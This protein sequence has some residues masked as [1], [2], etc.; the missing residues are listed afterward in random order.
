MLFQIFYVICSFAINI[1]WKWIRFMMTVIFKK[2]SWVYVS[3]FP[4][5][6]W[7]PGGSCPDCTY[8]NP[9]T[10]TQEYFLSITVIINLIH[11]QTMLYPN[12]KCNGPDV[13]FF[14]HKFP[15]IWRICW[16]TCGIIFSTHRVLSTKTIGPSK[17]F[18][19]CSR[20]WCSEG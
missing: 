14:I 20:H 1:V 15:H 2:Y 5:V 11:F 16:T 17:H 8:R 3:G 6:V 4:F 7:T 10:K 18:L 9:E 12:H 19:N 13:T